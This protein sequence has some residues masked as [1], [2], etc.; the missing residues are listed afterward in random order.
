[1][2]AFVQLDGLLSVLLRA[3]TLSSQSFAIGGLLFVTLVLEPSSCALEVSKRKALQWT[4]RWA[5]LV[6]IF[7]VTS[8]L[9]SGAVVMGLG[10]MKLSEVMGANFVRA[11]II[12]TTSAL[13]IAFASPRRKQVH[14]LIP[15][16]FILVASVLTSHAISRLGTRFPLLLFTAAHQAATAAWIGGLPYLLLCLKRTSPEAAQELCS[17]FSKLAQISVGVL[18]TAGTTLATIYVGS[19]KALY[20]TSYGVMLGAKA[21]L[22]GLLLMLGFLNLRLVRKGLASCNWILTRLKRLGEVEVAV[23]FSVILAA[24]SLTSL[25]PATDLATGLVARNEIASRLAPRWPHFYGYVALASSPQNAAQFSS[26]APSKSS[27][28]PSSAM[29]PILGGPIWSEYNHHWAGLIVLAMGLLAFLARAGKVPWA[30]NWPLLLLGLGVFVI[31]RADPENWPMGPNGFWISFMDPEVLLHRVF[32][33][34]IVAFGTFERKVQTTVVL[35]QRET[36]VFPTIV[37]LAGALLLTHSHNLGNVKEEVLAELSH[38][39]LAVIA[40]FAGSCRWLELRLPTED[41]IRSVTAWL[42][43]LCL[44][45]IGMILLNYR[46]S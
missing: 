22:F 39:S 26:S 25:P 6:A 15:A 2:P 13:F 36:L 29:R 40:I 27:A 35:R 31:Y 18:I 24:A 23:G 16:A 1:M 12:A 33:I 5:L 32:A 10:N 34:L 45:L 43:P 21:A 19:W 4:K 37:V 42:W 20:G 11:C 8:L 3:A 41:R 44:L 14:L 38:T 30:Q 46:E 7:Q 9:V 17:R 28:R